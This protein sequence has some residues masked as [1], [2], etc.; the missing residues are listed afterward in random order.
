MSYP[1]EAILIAFFAGIVLKE[2][3]EDY[4]SEGDDD[5]TRLD[6]EVNRLE[7][8]YKEGRL[9]ESQFE[10]RVGELLDHDTQRIFNVVRTIN[11][12]GGEIALETARYFDSYEAFQAATVDELQEVDQVGDKRARKIR[13]RLDAGE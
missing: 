2:L 13:D 1:Y 3:V 7:Q 8:A 12:I 10:A 11:G 5:G 4:V 9:P 6:E